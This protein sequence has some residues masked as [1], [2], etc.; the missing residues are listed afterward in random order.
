M[1]V[2]DV[3][4]TAAPLAQPSPESAV[5]LR[6]PPV[7]WQPEALREIARMLNGHAR[8]ALLGPIGGPAELALLDPMAGG[9]S[10]LKLVDDHLL[11][12][13]RWVLYPSELEPEWAGNDSRV[14]VSKA[15]EQLLGWSDLHEPPAAIVFSPPFGNRMADTYEPRETDK[16]DR[17]TYTIALGHPPSDGSAAA[18]TW[19]PAYRGAMAQIY[20]AVARCAGQHTLVIVEISDCQID[21]EPARVPEWTRWAL[22]H[23]GLVY[24]NTISWRERPLRYTGGAVTDD[25]LV[26]HGHRDDAD[27]DPIV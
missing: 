25:L 13:V 12:D 1:A 8:E 3:I 17:F 9:G 20:N 18:L 2:S 4:D 15:V 22:Q 14:A 5:E 26:F 23:A 11:H 6:E 24:R 21:G 7:P 10:I 16:S 19:G 27:G